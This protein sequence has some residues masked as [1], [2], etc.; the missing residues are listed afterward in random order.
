MKHLLIVLFTFSAI[1]LS[2]QQES[3]DTKSFEQGITKLQETLDTLDVSRIL[4]NLDITINDVKPSEDDLNAMKDQMSQALSRL[5]EI[6]FD[7]LEADLKSFMEQMGD[8]F[9]D[10]DGLEVLPQQSQEK[11]TK[12]KKI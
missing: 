3:N 9:G 4:E 7:K 2:A 11:D 5:E 10:F 8:I 12:L 6:D 1:I